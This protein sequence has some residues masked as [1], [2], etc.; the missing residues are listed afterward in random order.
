MVDIG[1]AETVA[2]AICF[3]LQDMLGVCLGVILIPVGPR[4][5]GRVEVFQFVGGVGEVIRDEHRL[6]GND[7]ERVIGYG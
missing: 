2:L 3:T 5:I 6:G 4:L 1:A 7:N